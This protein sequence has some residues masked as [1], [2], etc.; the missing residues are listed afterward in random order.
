M[1][2]AAQ[3]I[4]YLFAIAKRTA[5]KRDEIG[6]RYG[7][8]RGLSTKPTLQEIETGSEVFCPLWRL[9]CPLVDS[10]RQCILCK[11]SKGVRRFIV[12]LSSEAIDIGDI[13]PKIAL[14]P[15]SI[16]RRAVTALQQMQHLQQ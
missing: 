6:S 5:P 15:T 10:Q 9:T 7:L 16:Y 11:V 4:G 12:S 13:A 3:V 2:R 1:T 8:F 14:N